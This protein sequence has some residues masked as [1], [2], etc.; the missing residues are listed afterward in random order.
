MEKI[1]FIN[2]IYLTYVFKIFCL[3]FFF[4]FFTKFEIWM[5]FNLGQFWPLPG[6]FLVVTGEGVRGAD[7]CVHLEDRAQ[8]CC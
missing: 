3:F 4:F 5:V 8:G 6:T 7:V 2:R 1:N